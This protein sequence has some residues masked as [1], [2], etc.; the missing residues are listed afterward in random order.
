MSSRPF[1][2]A[3]PHGELKEIF[4]DV[5]F[6]TGTVRMGGPI[7]FSRNMTVVRDG[8]SLTLINSLRLDQA[9][10]GSLDSLGKVEHVIRI[11]GF[12]GMDDPF[13]K[14][15]Y[16]A[17]VWAIEGQRYVAGFDGKKPPYFEPDAWLTAE[18]E[19]PIAGAKLYL[20]ASSNPPEGLILLERDGGVVVSGDCLQNW[21]GP[22]R[23]F[24]FLAKPMMWLMGFLKPYNIGPGWLKQARPAPEGVRGILDL[25]FEHVLPVHGEPVICRAKELYRPAIQRVG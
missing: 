20:F 1:P 16:G 3:E 24:S 5:F 18:S 13:Y 8:D 14:D 4:P 21:A 12:H 6:V 10:L 25:P 19:L 2:A 7:A 9:G 17:K 23:Y 22:D 11:A 15:R